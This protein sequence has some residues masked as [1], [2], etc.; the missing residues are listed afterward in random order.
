MGRG[1]RMSAELSDWL[2]EL[3]A[4]DSASAA[5]VV[6]A[7]VAVVG[8]DDPARLALVR[9]VAVEPTDPREGVDLAYQDMLEYLQR[10]RRELAEVA[11]LRKR[12]SMQR[13][14]AEADAD[15]VRQASDARAAGTPACRGGAP[16][17]GARGAR[18]AP[19]T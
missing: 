10:F 4:T 2:T 15:T 11:S 6:A 1:L 5:E 16:R 7:V 12:L 8:A 19:A 14:A 17:A 9:P 3:C 13:A 18:A